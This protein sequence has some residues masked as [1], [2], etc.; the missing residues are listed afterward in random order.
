MNSVLTIDPEFEAKC[1]LL[2]E[3][4][5]SQLEENIVA[6]ELGLKHSILPLK[7]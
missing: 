6:E 2:T 7:F 5:L 3:E 1:P 4:E